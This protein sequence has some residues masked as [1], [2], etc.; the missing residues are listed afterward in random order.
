M[1]L[2]NQAGKTSWPITGATFILMHKQQ[3]KAATAKAVLNF[4]D[5]AYNNGDAMAKQ[6]DYVPMPS[7]VKQLVETNWSKT[8]TDQQGKAIWMQP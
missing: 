8:I 2:T 6:L 3:S 7:N 4:F 5:W 1:V